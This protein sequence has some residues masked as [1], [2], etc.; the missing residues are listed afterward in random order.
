MRSHVR[1]ESS[2]HGE[3]QCTVDNGHMETPPPPMD[4]MNN[5]QTDTT[6]KVTLLQ[7]ITSNDCPLAPFT[8]CGSGNGKKTGCI[9]SNGLVH[10]VRQWQWL[11]Q[12]QRK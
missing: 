10:T 9:G 4:R 8:Q 11:R 12:Q 3:V 1:E 6:E 2:Q 5:C 7:L